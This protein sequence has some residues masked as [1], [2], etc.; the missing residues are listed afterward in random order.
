MCSAHEMTRCWCALQCNAEP[1]STRW[2]CG[3]T[4]LCAKD[5]A[6]E[7]ALTSFAN[8]CRPCHFYSLRARRW[9]HLTHRS[10]AR[11]AESTSSSEKFEPRD[12]HELCGPHDAESGSA[13]ASPRAAC[14]S[15]AAP[16]RVSAAPVSLATA[17]CVP[18]AISGRE[19]GFLPRSPQH[20]T[21]L[22]HALRAAITGI[23]AGRA[24][25]STVVKVLRELL[26]PEGTPR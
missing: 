24:R 13:K 4:K 25:R 12:V 26:A 22:G 7:D 8:K 1:T 9:Q 18:N 11:L 14:P 16:S 6:L 20:C 5:A 21:R 3:D 23:L 17:I 19:H 2:R 15:R 10:A